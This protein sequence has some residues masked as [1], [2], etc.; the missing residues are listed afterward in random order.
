M[1]C[2]LMS[3][4]KCVKEIMHILY[5]RPCVILITRG[6]YHGMAGGWA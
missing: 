2:F 4:Y 5:E 6:I 3:Y 1:V